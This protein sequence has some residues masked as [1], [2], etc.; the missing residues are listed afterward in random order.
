MKQLHLQSLVNNW[1]AE[2]MDKSHVRRAQTEP[3]SAVASRA[4]SFQ[5]RRQFRAKL[6][7]SEVVYLAPQLGR[8]PGVAIVPRP[9]IDVGLHIVGQLMDENALVPAAG[10]PRFL[11]KPAFVPGFLLIPSPGPCHHSFGSA[12]LR[13]GRDGRARPSKYHV[14]T[15]CRPPPLSSPLT[16]RPKRT[17]TKV[18]PAFVQPASLRRK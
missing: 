4:S 17:G 1:R 16:P 2:N 7:Q 8:L 9:A 11:G 12:W 6:D 18:N 3:R 14:L 5:C 15:A 13:D 10:R